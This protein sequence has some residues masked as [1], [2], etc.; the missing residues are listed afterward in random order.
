MNYTTVQIII[1]I[2]N[3]LNINKKREITSEIRNFIEEISKK[4]EIKY[5]NFKKLAYKINNYETTYFVA[6]QIQ[7]KKIGVNKKI[8]QIEE[9]LNTYEEIIEFKIIE[10]N[11]I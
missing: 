7:I 1:L 8:R 10:K 4:I 11:K 9:K 5:K 6:M 2:N 3:S